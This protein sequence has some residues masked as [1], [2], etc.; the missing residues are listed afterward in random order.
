MAAA[1]NTYEI[2]PSRIEK[3]K[4][5]NNYLIWRKEVETF[6]VAGKMDEVALGTKM[7]PST[8]PDDQK[9]WTRLDKSAQ[10]I[11]LDTVEPEVKSSIQM[12]ATSFEMWTLLK[13]TYEITSTSSV[14]DLLAQFYSLVVTED[15]GPI[16]TINRLQFIAG[17]LNSM[18]PKMIKLSSKQIL[19][20]AVHSLKEEKYDSMV[21]AWKA[22]PKADQTLPNLIQFIRLFMAGKYEKRVT[23]RALFFHAVNPKN[24][25]DA[26]GKG[27]K[28]PWNCHNSGQKGH[29]KAECR[30]GKK[31]N[32]KNGNQPKS[33]E[34]SEPKGNA[35]E[36]MARAAVV[37]TV[38][39]R[40]SHL[41]PADVKV[42]R[43]EAF[44][45]ICN[46]GANTHLCG[47]RDLYSSYEEFDVPWQ[48]YPANL[49]PVECPG[50]GTVVVEA[51]VRNKWE[52]LILENVLHYPGA[53]NQFSGQVY[54]KL[55][56]RAVMTATRT[57]FKNLSTGEETLE[58]ERCYDGLHAMVFRPAN[59]IPTHM[60]KP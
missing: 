16:E 52:T 37:K 51:R 12:S 20:K 55:G 29:W 31:D 32:N 14:K 34:K 18:D 56:H 26:V 3:L 48:L 23:H 8:G 7:Y 33:D 47:R 10:S 25:N 30:S 44:E 11:I 38:G 28:N 22:H 41:K 1:S 40:S 5:S 36:H 27:K 9:A 58:A 45:W 50:M 6:L 2:D 35:K 46:L 42:G 54:N 43:D 17:Q 49:V 60:V 39:Q 15:C 24:G 53:V 4:G 59:S 19:A 21:T 57:V 13:N